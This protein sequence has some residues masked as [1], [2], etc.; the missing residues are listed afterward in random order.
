MEGK[1]VEKKSSVLRRVA[2]LFVVIVTLA[3][4]TGCSHDQAVYDGSE[5]DRRQLDLTAGQIDTRMLNRYDDLATGQQ[6]INMSEAV[7]QTI[8]ARHYYNVR[9]LRYDING[10]A[11]V[12]PE[13]PGYSS[14]LNDK[15]YRIVVKGNLEQSVEK[16]EAELAE[17]DQPGIKDGAGFC[18]VILEWESYSIFA[19]YGHG[20]EFYSLCD[21]D[22]DGK[23]DYYCKG[24]VATVGRYS[25]CDGIEL[26]TGR[27]T[28]VLY[29]ENGLIPA[30]EGILDGKRLEDIEKLLD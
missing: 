6:L 14:L 30:E 5:A 23:W 10:G 2:L 15:E 27:F 12:Y 7:A 21:L 18:G 24:K 29:S 8:N 16:V 19:D 9:F 22:A 11:H 25:T 3:G 28:E 20:G 17:C 26:G 1:N 4:L 13:I